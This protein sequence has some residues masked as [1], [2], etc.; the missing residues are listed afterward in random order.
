MPHVCGP[1]GDI[2]LL[3]FVSAKTDDSEG[4]DGRS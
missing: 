2:F 1:P 4:E 3:I